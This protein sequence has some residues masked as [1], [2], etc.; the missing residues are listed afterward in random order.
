[1]YKWVQE[2]GVVA[3]FTKE[4][5]VCVCGGVWGKLILTQS[6]GKEHRS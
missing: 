4:G 3:R 2:P 5:G 1:M 6:F